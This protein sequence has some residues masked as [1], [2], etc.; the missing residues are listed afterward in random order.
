ME[1][2]A[3]FTVSVCTRIY[4]TST[5]PIS[6]I[7]IKNVVL[8]ANTGLGNRGDVLNTISNS[9]ITISAYS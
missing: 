3:L 7:V 8:N 6:E 9:N 1:S 4:I 2:L 5:K